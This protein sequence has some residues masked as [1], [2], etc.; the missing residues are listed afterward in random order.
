VPVWYSYNAMFEAVK[1][2]ITNTCF[3][4]CDVV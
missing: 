1:M 4:L 2:I 3:L